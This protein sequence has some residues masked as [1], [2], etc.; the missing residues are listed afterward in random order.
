M[1]ALTT[2]AKAK[3]KLADNMRERRLAMSLTQ[4]GLSKRSG[5]ALPTLRKFEQSGAVSIDNLFKL[6]LVVG[7]LNEVVDAS[8]LNQ[9]EFASI[10]DVVSGRTQSIRKR[11]SK[12]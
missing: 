8:E 12:S 1:L 3:R 5:V 2:P 7:G 6:M 11:G 10:D 9:A 4:A